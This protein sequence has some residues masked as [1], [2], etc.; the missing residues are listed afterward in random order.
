MSNGATVVTL[1]SATDRAPGVL[2]SLRELA[3][4]RELLWNVTLREIKV[5]YKQTLLGTAWAILQPLSFMVLFTVF[6]SYLIR[7][8][9]E[10]VPY[11]LFTL[12]ALLPWMFFATSLS[13]AIPSLVGN[14]DL[15]RKVYFPREIFPLASVLAAL[16]DFAIA[17]LPFAGMVLYYRV[18]LT[19]QALYVIPLLGV[20]IVFTVGLALFFSALAAHYRDVKHALPLAIQLWMFATPII[21]PISLI[22]E[23]FK[24][25]FLLN[26]MAGVI[27]GYRRVLLHGSAPDL[28][29]AGLAAFVAVLAFWGGVRYFK[30]VEARLADVI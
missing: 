9:S 29:A 23:R 28:R 19:S 13:F 8:P 3:A 15:I 30:Q 17:C 12:T 21:Y 27:D 11:P 24:T 25:I 26:P 1:I 20:Q 18:P 4:Y 7:V 22:P 10:G 2:R 5:R 16:L 14:A 6:F